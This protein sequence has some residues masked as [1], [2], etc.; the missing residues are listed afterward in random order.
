MSN[1][2][3]NSLKLYCSSV[4]TEPR[5]PENIKFP[6]RVFGG[7]KLCFQPRWYK[8]FPWLD[9]DI[10]SDTVFCYICKCAEE[11]GHLTS[12]HTETAFTSTGFCKWKQAL[13]KKK[14]FAR[15]QGSEAHKTAVLRLISA[16]ATSRDLAVMIDESLLYQKA[17]NRRMFIKIVRSVQYLLSRGMALRGEWQPEKGEEDNNLL[18]L[19]KFSCYGKNQPDI[20]EW[21]SKKYNKFISPSIINEIIQL[22]G[23]ETIRLVVKRIKEADCKYFSIL[24]DETSDVSKKEQLVVCIRWIDN[25]LLPHEDYLTIRVLE[26]LKAKS[27]SD[28]VL[29]CLQI[30]GLDIEDAR[31]QC[32]DGASVMKGE[33][34]GVA[35]IIK[36]KNGSCL[37]IHCH[38]H[39]L[40]LACG[41]TIKQIPSLKEA[42][43]IAR[44]LIKFIRKSPKKS[45]NLMNL[46][47]ESDNPYAGVHDFSATRW[48]VRGG[49]MES[50]INNFDEI[51]ELLGNR[52]LIT[53]SEQRIKAV[54][55]ATSIHKFSFL[56]GCKLAAMI[57]KQFDRLSQ[58]LQDPTLSAVESYKIA[59]MTIKT[60]QKDRSEES[61]TLFFKSLKKIQ[62]E[63]D[64]E[65]ALLPRRRKRPAKITNY[66]TYMTQHHPETVE[67]LYRPIYFEALDMG[68]RTVSERFDQEDFKIQMSMEQMLIRAA[69]GDLNQ[70]KSELINILPIFPKDFTEEGLLADLHHI[71][72]QGWKAE[73]GLESL[74][75]EF[76]NKEV[77]KL[78]P[79][80][81]RAIQ[82]VLISPATNAVSERLFSKLKLLKTQYSPPINM[83]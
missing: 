20:E 34:G 74:K 59:M 3:K 6:A 2:I 36:E 55:L 41:D 19:L 60:M 32:Y 54:G 49:A 10:E 69:E 64:I 62:E 45:L 4:P 7:K 33:H 83:W 30:N 48:T 52:E 66:G 35:S 40:N 18:A 26:D 46:R 78:L 37:Y 42:F 75:C 76:K 51:T 17:N 43:D 31:G 22:F 11:L 14:G 1:L 79:E 58:T 44:E 13:E 68:I 5:Q 27:I 77:R 53:D 9:Y 63:L 28:I 12:H 8:L 50:I 72:A 24:A 21:L 80:A 15:H 57:M 23:K 70:S 38:G 82:I 71:S 61:F 47:K 67:E 81:T 29:N 73:N 39:S 16:P 25:D 65:E 56:F